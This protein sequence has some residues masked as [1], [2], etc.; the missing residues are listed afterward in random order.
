MEEVG[1]GPKQSPRGA[2]PVGDVSR[3]RG[4][5]RGAG[6]VGWSLSKA[7]PR[8]PSVG[9]GLRLALVSRGRLLPVLMPSQFSLQT[10]WVQQ[11]Q[12]GRGRGALLPL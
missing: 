1:G 3:Q 12:P 11:S 9:A 4:Y 8:S 2:E 5:N 7:V 6:S 10:V